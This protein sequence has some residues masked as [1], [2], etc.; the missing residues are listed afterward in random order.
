MDK[1]Q[2]KTMILKK[3]QMFNIYQQAKLLLLHILESS[4]LVMLQ[5][6]FW[7]KKK[8]FI[9]LMKKN[10]GQKINHPI[11][12]IWQMKNGWF[13]HN[14]AISNTM[15]HNHFQ[16]I[17]CVLHLSDNMN[18]GEQDKMTKIIPFYDMIAKCCIK[19][20]TNAL[21]LSIDESLLLYYGRN[22]SKQQ[23]QN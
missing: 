22:N 2:M 6:V 11:P 1:F 18:L 5:T 21:D 12:W 23:M 17:L 16:K 20:P 14:A 15:S 4:L 10:A 7:P 8:S 3:V 19:N 13:I 9:I